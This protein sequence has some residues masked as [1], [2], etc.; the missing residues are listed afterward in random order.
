MRFSRLST[1]YGS[2]FVLISFDNFSCMSHNT[3]S[4]EVP[5]ID[6]VFWHN[7]SGPISLT[8]PQTHY[9]ALQHEC[10]YALNLWVGLG[11]RFRLSVECHV[12]T[13]M[14]QIW[15]HIAA[16]QPYDEAAKLNAVL[17]SRLSHANALALR[18]ILRVSQPVG[19][20]CWILDTLDNGI[21]HLLTSLCHLIELRLLSE[22]K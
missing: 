7:G 19:A 9:I 21:S 16:L 17:A 6:L 11:K 3:I 20:D 5:I 18:V 8:H 14:T 12:S 1:G 22:R 10:P 4:L 13:Q 2:N 15:W